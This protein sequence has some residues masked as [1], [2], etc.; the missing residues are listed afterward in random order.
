MM[1]GISN[2][3]ASTY[4]NFVSNNVGSG[5]ICVPVSPSMVAYSQFEHVQGVAVSD[6]QAGVDIDKVEIL[7][8][9]IDQLVSMKQNPPVPSISED[10]TGM[11]ENQVDVL[12]ND[13]QSKIQDAAARMESNPYTLPGAP[14]PQTGIIFDINA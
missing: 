14:L 10:E 5:K 3:N 7:N 2:M 13:C 4:T 11:T 12:I 8:R 1:S 9:L 6:G